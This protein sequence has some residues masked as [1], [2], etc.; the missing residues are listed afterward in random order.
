MSGWCYLV[1]ILVL[2]GL[3][4]PRPVADKPLAITLLGVTLALW[5]ATIAIRVAIEVAQR[6]AFHL[7]LRPGAIWLSLAVT[8]G[9]QAIVT[10]IRANGEPLSTGQLSL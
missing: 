2:I 9:V 8:I 1:L 7:D 6:F 10:H 3:V 4:P 5:F